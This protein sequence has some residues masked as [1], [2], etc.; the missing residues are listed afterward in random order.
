MPP[1]RRQPSERAAAARELITRP[2]TYVPEVPS[3]LLAP[4][5]SLLVGM[6]RNRDL[7]STT[8][9][10]GDKLLH[11][12]AT[13]F[14]HVRDGKRLNA[15]ATAFYVKS[16]KHAALYVAVDP[17][18]TSPDMATY[19][20]V[21][22]IMSCVGEV[23]DADIDENTSSLVKI[24]IEKIHAELDETRNVKLQASRERRKNF[25]H[26]VRVIGGTALTLSLVGGGIFY[27]VKRWIVDPHQR[28]VAERKAFDESDFQLPGEGTEI[29]RAT[30]VGVSG[31]TLK[32]IPSYHDGDSLADARRV[33][34]T[35]ANGCT[36]IKTDLPDGVHV[37][38]VSKAHVPFDGSS[39]SVAASGKTFEVCLTDVVDGNDGS[40]NTSDIAVQARTH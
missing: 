20:I 31:T 7:L 22:G 11:T 21:D 35:E 2:E 13:K 4:A 12:P 38:L 24:A 8:K 25:R 14:T 16:E 27:G 6:R 3:D 32:S 30:V 15:E 29:S 34:F 40:E 33:E 36:E 10:A 17:D 28:A 39:Y 9:Q 18:T 26:G 19:K 1:L 5:N 37:V 23:E